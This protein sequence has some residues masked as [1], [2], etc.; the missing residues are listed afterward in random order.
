MTQIFG[1][2]AT[3]VTTIFNA[4]DPDIASYLPASLVQALQQPEPSPG[5][6]A[7]AHAH[8]ETLFTAITPFVPSPV[9]SR[10]LAHP[11]RDRIH[12]QYLFG[13]VVS[14]IISG[15]SELSARFAQEKH[16][17]S[18]EISML[19]RSVF[20]ILLEEIDA[21]GGGTV[22][23]GSDT[24]LAFFDAAHL[25]T[26]H[27][28]LACAAALAA[29]QRMADV[30]AVTTSQG[31]VTLQL[32]I[33]I[34]TSNMFIAEAG[35]ADHMELVTNGEAIN[36]A[37]IAQEHAAPGEII[38]SNETRQSMPDAQ[39]QPRIPGFFLLQSCEYQSVSVVSAQTAWLSEA[40]SLVTLAKLLHCIH[41]LS[42]YKPYGL[43][44]NSRM[45]QP[46][47][48]EFRAVTVLFNDLTAI[49][50][51]LT[52]LK[53]P[54]LLEN[55][56][57]IIGHML[58]LYYVQAQKIIHQY[59]GIVNT[60]ETTPVGSRMVA[61]FGAPV[62]YEDDPMRAVRAALAMRD[63]TDTINSEAAAVVQEW[64]AQHPHQQSLLRTQHSAPQPRMGIAS[65]ILFAG[66]TGT[67]QRHEYTV[68]GA[69]INVAA[70]VMAVAQA[71]EVLLA[72]GSYRAV[73]PML[74][75]QLQHRVRLEATQQSMPVFLALHECAPQAQEP[76]DGTAFIGRKHELALFE[77]AAACIFAKE[78]A[79]GQ[80][81]A[82]AGEAG[83]GKS[84]FVKEAL[85][86]LRSEHPN[87]VVVHETCQSFEQTTPYSAIAR[88]LRQAL[89][90]SATKSVA[91][92]ELQQQLD[93]LVPEWSHLAPLLA[94][95]FD[96][97]LDETSLTATLSA[98]Q[99]NERLHELITEVYVA[100]SRR[101]PF[102]IV[103]DDVHWAD[104]SSRA[105]LLRIAEEAASQP[106]LLVL[107]YRTQLMA[108][109][110]WSEHEHCAA[111]TLQELSQTD[112]EA[113]MTALLGTAPPAELQHVLE[114][115]H[116]NPFFLEEMLQYLLQSGA[117][118]QDYQHQW[119]L[120][121]PPNAA[122]F[123]SRVEQLIMA[124]LDLLSEEAR[125]L[126]QTA[127]VL[128]QRFSRQLL[129]AIAACSTDDQT[130][131]ASLV[132]AGLIISDGSQAMYHF[133]HA[134]VH[135]V[136]YQ[137]IRASRRC[138][139]HAR[140]AH[141]IMHE[142]GAQIDAYQV[143]L[144]QHYLGAEQPDA[145][146]PHFLRAAQQAQ[147]HYANRDALSLY[148]Q[149]FSTA[150]WRQRSLTSGDVALATVLY[151][152]VADVYSIVGDY[153]RAREHYEFLL[154]L[155]TIHQQASA[156]QQAALQRKIGTTFEQQGNTEAALRWFDDSI[157]TFAAVSL[158][159]AVQLE[160]ARILSD[161][162]W[163]YFRQ[164]NL[165]EAREHLE[166]A[167]ILIG[168]EEAP[169]ER[170]RMFNRLGGVAYASGDF[171]QARRYVEQSLLVSEQ[172]GNLISQAEALSNLGV[173]T[174]SQ[175]EI[176][177]SIEYSWL[178]LKMNE[179]I[180]SRRGRAIAA[181]N[182]A[183]A[184]YADEQYQRAEEY[185]SRALEWATS[186][187]DVY[188]QML[189]LLNLGYTYVALQQWD[190]SE[191]ATRRG[192]FIAVQLGAHAAELDSYTLLGEIA[193]GRGDLAAAQAAHQQ[194]VL[195]A[196]DPAIEEY[197]RFK[198]LE[199]KIAFMSG[200][201]HAATALLE[202]A[203]ALFCQLHNVP[204]AQQ[205]R[206]LLDKIP[207]KVNRS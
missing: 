130:H 96:L 72:S 88:M 75:G 133:K 155:L 175:G 83:I 26:R 48:G 154:R 185:F 30:A 90:L 138:E 77:A 104:H 121:S 35:D 91:A 63:A 174:V 81:I 46:Q 168:T 118:Q 95:L 65:G 171:A 160:H 179:Q 112:S 20:S 187:R 141:T 15:V 57:S 192:Q 183:Y 50:R 158:N 196:T 205:T 62:A 12:G 85:Q 11:N 19:M 68:T 164:N 55:D 49:S 42:P 177:A 41:R 44:M 66:L 181:I 159:S 116:G 195:R 140:A 76:A 3:V 23:F 38:I 180:S 161:I 166:Q 87:L 127:A 51:R 69:T 17:G 101:H 106:L 182:L 29:Q 110:P 126:A 36:Q 39:T 8:L 32:R 119:M 144:A 73:Q 67:P 24:L 13:T 184:L 207:A 206:K 201:I 122:P 86:T 173:L 129:Y 70:K 71:G 2:K 28:T 202:A 151:E 45:A 103:I 199:A 27:A 79:H 136:I 162:G 108:D 203:E 92:T 123:P 197:G 18:E 194:G 7:D 59:G 147:A 131:A 89:H 64:V 178:A 60:I 128:G 94:R 139:L 33:G 54:A 170:A 149:A 14:F 200:D 135:D 157:K 47:H 125:A 193:L 53:L 143:V 188:H 152:N 102:A 16:Q 98:D 153:A 56:V 186:A 22:K 117:L 84:R 58:N 169:E 4:A 204:E 163:I 21:H 172:S 124:R 109:E 43:P 80:I 142:Y 37:V 198:R 167:L 148:Q 115:T 134:L 132:E 190:A 5:A 93:T 34:H 107:M 82:V 150:P 114:Q 99:R 113:L 120:M 145:A 74:H 156:A 189:A 40:P 61:L 137:N 9:L 10:T 1:P 165:A 176:A 191:Q 31:M 97:P 146:F 100:L 52:T 78:A 6:I 105:V 25:G 111:I